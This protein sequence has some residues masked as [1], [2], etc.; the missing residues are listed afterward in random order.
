MDEGFREDERVTR[1]HFGLYH[2]MG[3]AFEAPDVPGQ[4]VDEVGFMA[5]RDADE[6]A[7]TGPLRAREST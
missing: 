2:V 4:A 1:F 7:V 6:P 5:A 3:V